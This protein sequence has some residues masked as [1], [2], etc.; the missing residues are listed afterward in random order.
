MRKHGTWTHTL[1]DGIL[2]GKS[3]RAVRSAKEA[4][5]DRCKNKVKQKKSEI[6]KLNKNRNTNK[7]NK[8]KN[9]N[10]Q[11]NH[12]RTTTKVVQV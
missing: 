3:A 1:T 9:K 11:D 6:K 4:V 12:V 5:V 8:N 2:A 7:Q 10:N